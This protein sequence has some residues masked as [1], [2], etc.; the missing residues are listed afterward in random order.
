LTP[1]S[2]RAFVVRAE[3]NPEGTDAWRP[4]LTGSW[5]VFEIAPEHSSRL[6]E[7]HAT[8]PAG[9]LNAELAVISP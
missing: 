7:P 8:E 2:E 4:Y 9:I 3:N 1:Y 5:R 6:R